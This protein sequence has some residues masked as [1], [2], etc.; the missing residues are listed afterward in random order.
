M[1]F[2]LAVDVLGVKELINKGNSSPA[3]KDGWIISVLQGETNYCGACGPSVK[4]CIQLYIFK[5][6]AIRTLII[7]S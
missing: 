3:G 6:A 1:S 7:S 5:Y 4:T 2:L